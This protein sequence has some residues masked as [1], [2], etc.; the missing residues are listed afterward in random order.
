MHLGL[1]PYTAPLAVEVADL[2]LAFQ[3]E[4]ALGAYDDRMGMEA[5]HSQVE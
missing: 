4:V 5:V 2:D 3:H 1:E